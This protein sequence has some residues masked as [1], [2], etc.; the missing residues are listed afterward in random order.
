MVFLN[1]L[2]TIF[3]CVEFIALLTLEDANEFT[4]RLLWAHIIGNRI[5]DDPTM[6]IVQEFWSIQTAQAVVRSCGLDLG[7]SWMFR[8]DIEASLW[9]VTQRICHDDS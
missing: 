5:I 4:V 9:F 7:N 6:A 2:E 8:V 1:I 3:T